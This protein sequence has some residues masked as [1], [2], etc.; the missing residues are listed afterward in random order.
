MS[1]SFFVTMG[2]R[3]WY[4]SLHSQRWGQPTKHNPLHIRDVKRVPEPLDPKKLP[5][6]EFQTTRKLPKNF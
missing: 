4:D 5:E 3:G 1:F 2:P 6:P